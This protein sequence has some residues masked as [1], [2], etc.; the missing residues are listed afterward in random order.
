MAF[1]IPGKPMGKARSRVTKR[2][3]AYTPALTVSYENLVKFYFHQKAEETGWKLK[4]SENI[5][6]AICAR[7]E[8]PKSIS[9][10]KRALMIDGEVR[11]VKKP[12]WDNIGKIICDSLNGIA[13]HDDS[14]IVMG[15]VEKT[16][17][18]CPRVDVIISAE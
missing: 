2:G 4:E 8:I 17:D 13:Y 14:Q 3:F 7:F 9:K 10:K 11:P 18:E 1:T 5:S 15:S 6:I 16:Y 12:D